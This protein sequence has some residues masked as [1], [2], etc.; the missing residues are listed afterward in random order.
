MVTDNHFTDI[1]QALKAK[2]E[3]GVQLN[4]Q[5]VPVQIVTPDP[6][7]VELELPCLTLQLTDMRRDL[8]RTDNERRVEKDVEGMTAA[9]RP[10]TEPYNLHYSIGVHAGQT[11]ETRLLLEQVLLVVDGSTIMTTD[12][13]GR[14][15][16]LAR[17]LSFRDYSRE[18]DYSQS[19]GVVVK[20]RLEPNEAETVPLIAETAF[21]AEEV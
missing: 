20:T 7:F 18:R 5:P 12:V 16:Y 15:V 19:I 14:E 3:G 13:L 10:R 2:L 8:E 9:V 11:R 1:D 4:G 6:D 21:N 17:E